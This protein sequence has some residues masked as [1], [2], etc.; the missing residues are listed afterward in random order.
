MVKRL[1]LKWSEVLIVIGKLP[2]EKCYGQK[3]CQEMG[4]AA[5]HI[6]NI[7]PWLEKQKMIRRKTGR[8]IRYI[9]LTVRGKNIANDILSM[10]TDL[11]R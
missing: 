6:R 7:I 2:E 10:K 3:I 1:F 5:S 8:K 9:A 4:G 11:N